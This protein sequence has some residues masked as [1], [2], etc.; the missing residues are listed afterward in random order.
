MTAPDIV[1]IDA[2]AVAIGDRALALTGA[3]GSGKSDLALRLIDG[4]AMLIADDRVE[5]VLQSG[6]VCCRAPAA[7]PAELRGRIEVR[8]VGIV[9]VPAVSGAVPLRWWVELVQPAAI[10]RMPPAEHRT[11]LGCQVPLLRLA[12]FEASA[13]AKLRLAAGVGPGLI[14]GRE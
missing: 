14:M 3:S 5:L 7:M 10:E 6:A 9:P 13:V 8:G 1:A 4:G 2:T 12:P 11:V